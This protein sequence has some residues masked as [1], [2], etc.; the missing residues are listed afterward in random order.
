LLVA[1]RA[2]PGC[3][4]GRAFGLVGVL[5]NLGLGSSPLIAAAVGVGAGWR[6]SFL[7]GI[8][9]ALWLGVLLWREPRF[10]VAT[11]PE[12][13]QSVRLRWRDVTLP[14]LLL[15]ALETLMGF[16]FQGL[17]TFLPAHLAQHGRIT[18]L[19]EAHVTR[20]G[21]LASVAYLLGGWGHALAGRLMGRPRRE[22]IFLVTIVLTSLG[23]TGM[24]TTEGMLLV[25]SSVI[26]SFTHFGLATMSNTLIASH[27]PPH[28]GGTAFGITFV[29]A[30]GVGSMASGTMGVVAEHW[31][32]HAV[33]LALAA[34]AAVAVGLVAVFTTVTGAGG[35]ARS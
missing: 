1:L 22:A 11:P 14:L 28:L 21:I 7:L 8:L 9:P 2:V 32:L 31:G 17:S 4:V 12:G 18:G 19:T 33:F 3:N 6:Y 29:L 25:I 5:G 15:F 35:P 20:G 24:G 16:V 13:G 23:L 26:L 30:L 34:V 10:A 27:A